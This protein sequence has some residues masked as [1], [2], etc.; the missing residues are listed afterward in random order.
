MPGGYTG[1][2]LRVDLSTGKVTSEDTSKYKDFLGGT[3]L[4][5]KILWDEVKPGTKAWDPENRIIFGVGPLTGSGSPLSGRVSITSLWP[6]HINELPGTGHMGGHWGAE[7]KFAG[8]DSLIVQGKAAKPVWI[9]IKDDKVEIRDAKNLW[10]NGIFRATE[11]ICNEVGSDTQVAAIGQAGENLVRLSCVLCNRSHSAGGVG[12]I[13][14][15][16]NLKAIAI[17]GSGSVAIAADKKAWKDLT[18]E[19]LSLLGANS[20][21]VVPRTPQPWAEYYGNTRWTARKG[22]YWGAANP[23]I[24]TGECSADDLNRIGYRTHKGVLDHGEGVGEQHLVRMGGCYSCPIRCHAYTEMPA[25]ETKYGVSRYQGNTCV[26]NSFGSAFFNL[27]SASEI[28]MEASQLGSALADDYGLWNDYGQW[29]RDF[30]YLYRNSFLK[31]RLPAAEYNSIPWQKLESGDP[32]F[33]QDLFRRITFKEGELGKT[34][35]EGP[36]RV[37]KKWP[38]LAAWHQTYESSCWKDDHAKHHANES[39]GQI[40]A[41]LNML[42]NRD[43]QCHTHNSFQG[44]GLPLSLMKEISAELFGAPDAFDANNDIKPMNKSKAVF[45]KMSIIYLELHNSLTACNYTLPTWASP[46]KD[47]K[48]R[49][50]VE[51]EAKVLSAVTGEKISRADIEKT[52]LRI[53]TMFRAL[54]AL[55]A[56]EKNMRVNHD[57]MNDWVFNYPA[58]AKPFTPGVAK[59]DKADIELGKDL[60]YAELGWDKATGMPTKA[61]LDSLGLGYVADTLAKAGLLPA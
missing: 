16:K 19:Y 22:L 45:V 23:P 58:S 2:I 3:G 14:G 21:G 8:W 50:D 28:R 59:M 24:E 30:V 31:A 4:G 32:S 55:Y 9:Y 51:M 56:N 54:T 35:A 1:K 27:P 13:L 10:G 40:G 37:A 49:G 47:R 26:G 34:F 46:R 33:L 29:P 44:S 20:G 60:L 12:S 5:Y 38:E 17:K 48:Y 57:K 41:L 39:G 7:L 15:S 43:V 25:L 53:L 52:G 42:Y 61:T 11:E 6:V 36:A 18:Y